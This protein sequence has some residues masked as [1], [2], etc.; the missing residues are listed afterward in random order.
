MQDAYTYPGLKTT[1]L[2]TTMANSAA[3]C[4]ESWSYLYGED[5]SLDR[6]TIEGQVGILGG[7]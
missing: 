5:I 7:C 6:A 4:N 1:A 2:E 3:R